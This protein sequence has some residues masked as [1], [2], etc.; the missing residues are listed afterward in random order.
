MRVG[1]ISTS[2]A[3][4]G[5]YTIVTYSTRTNS[6]A[7]TIG[8]LM[9]A[10]SAFAGYRAA[11]S[12]ASSACSKAVP[13]VFASGPRASYD[14]IIVVPTRISASRPDGP[15]TF[16]YGT[17]LRTS[18]DLATSQGD[19]NFE[20]PTGL[21][22]SEQVEGSALTVTGAVASAASSAGLAKCVMALKRGK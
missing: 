3:A 22:W 7:T 15:A 16:S 20:V 2:I 21:N 5:P 18:D 10:G 11:P 8:V 19:V 17:P 14:A 4:I 12:A 9:R 13:R 1:N 6:S